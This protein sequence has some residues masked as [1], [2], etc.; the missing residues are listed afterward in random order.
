MVQPV[1]APSALALEGAPWML[2]ELDGA[3][4]VPS[5][6]SRKAFLT[7]IASSKSFHA[8]AGC[9]SISGGYDLPQDLSIRFKPGPMTMMACSDPLMK[10][11][12]AFVKALQST[13]SYRIAGPTLELR[14]ASNALARFSAGTPPPVK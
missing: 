3:P 4:P 9:N 13:T 8:S 10:Q 12:Q 7:L 11:E 5:Q 2:T 6:G 14:D 1:A